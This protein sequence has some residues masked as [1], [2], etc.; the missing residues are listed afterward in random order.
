MAHRVFR[1]SSR[2]FRVLGLAGFE[3]V[4]RAVELAFCFRFSEVFIDE[5]TDEGGG[6]DAGTE[7]FGI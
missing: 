4:C 1:A 6:R 7:S 3:V 2:G 5:H